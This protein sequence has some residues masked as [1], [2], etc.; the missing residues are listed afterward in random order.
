MS[1]MLKL[2]TVKKGGTS[3]CT[4]LKRD[5]A[6]DLDVYITAVEDE[7]AY[8]KRKPGFMTPETEV[9]LAIAKM[10]HDR[11]EHRDVVEK[12]CP[13]GC[14]FKKGSTGVW[15]MDGLCLSPYHTDCELG[16]PEHIKSLRPRMYNN[17]DPLKASDGGVQRPVYGAQNE[18]RFKQV[19]TG[20]EDRRKNNSILP[21]DYDEEDS[22]DAEGGE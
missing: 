17:E 13:L 12:T 15:E 3:A 18:R 2:N 11:S 21:P 16:K 19:F 1:L 4:L 10:K 9:D 6:L 20:H 5:D 7:V 22:C 14:K 8:A